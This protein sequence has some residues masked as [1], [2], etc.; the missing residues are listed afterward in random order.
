MAVFLSILAVVG[1]LAGVVLGGYLA[2]RTQKK[3]WIL[4]SK[5]EEYRELLSTLT[6]SFNVLLDLH[7][8]NV[9]LGSDEQ[10]AEHDARLKALAVIGDRLFIADEIKRFD[11]SNRW[12]KAIYQFD[13]DYD[14]PAFAR[15]VGGILCRHHRLREENHRVKKA[16]ALSIIASR[17]GL[18]AAESACRTIRSRRAASFLYSS[19]RYSK[20]TSSDTGVCDSSFQ[21]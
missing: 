14:S 11:V 4:D 3:H 7:V 5:K 19:Y 8:A 9:G 12:R 1:S 20:F 13:D 18:L 15:T 2:T 16:H 17:Y 10:R 21:I 6:Q